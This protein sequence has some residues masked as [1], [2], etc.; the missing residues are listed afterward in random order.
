MQRLWAG[1][2]FFVDFV[3]VFLIDMSIYLGG[4]DIG[5]A[6]HFLHAAQVGT[7]L[8]QVCAKTVAQ[9]MSGDFTGHPGT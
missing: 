1:M 8:E 4:G 6:E 9:C 2:I 5:M 3:Q 7:A